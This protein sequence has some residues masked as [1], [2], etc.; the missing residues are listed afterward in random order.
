M[1]KQMASA[2]LEFITSIMRRTH[3]RI[4]VHAFHYVHW[5]AIVLVWYPVSN[6][7]QQQGRIGWMAGI[8]IGAVV[9]GM[10]LS[11]VREA[12]LAKKP[13]LAG[14]NTFISK[15][16]QLIVLACVGAGMVLSAIGPATH[17]ID[18]PHVPILWG[19]VYANLAFMLGVVYT[20]EFLVAGALIFLGAIVAM[21]LPD[22]AGYIL[23][24]CMGLGLI[25]P[26]VMGERRVK[27]MIAA[28]A[29]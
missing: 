22:Y 6:W 1:D 25:V 16:V 29:G 20:R 7:F 14:E 21:F 26:G 17:V 2:E 4:D 13:R 9:L 10:V 27:R 12:L 24:P 5:G 15:Q 3:Q 18:G 23:G 28:D 11:G 19:F 8:G